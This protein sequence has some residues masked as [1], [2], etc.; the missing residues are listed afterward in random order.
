MTKTI[1]K[2]VTGEELD[3]AV[4]RGEAVYV[5]IMSD[6]IVYQFGNEERLYQLCSGSKIERYKLI[7][8]KKI[9]K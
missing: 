8:T 2:F 9:N 4:E 3:E 6:F 7:H 5:G 1:D